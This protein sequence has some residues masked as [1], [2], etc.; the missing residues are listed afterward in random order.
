MVEVHLRRK[1][2]NN[3]NLSFLLKPTNNDEMHIKQK[4]TKL[5]LKFSYLL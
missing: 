2:Y 3:L 1:N 4:L 5:Q